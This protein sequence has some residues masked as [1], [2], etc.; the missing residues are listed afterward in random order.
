MGGLGINLPGLLTQIVSFLVLF[1]VLYKVLY[2]P[3]TRMLDERS[4]RIEEGLE[5]AERAKEEAVSS[6]E[7]IGEELAAAR[8]EGQRL[9]AEAR[10][11]AGG[12]RREQEARVREEMNEILSR[13]RAQIE[14]ER[15]AA[16]EA[17]RSRFSVPAI[18]AA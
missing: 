8:A 14:R 10:D 3:V 5:A 17:G 18:S 2:G 11:A 12:W 6:A 9:I 15:D 7:R 4:K 1:V 16:I 13:A